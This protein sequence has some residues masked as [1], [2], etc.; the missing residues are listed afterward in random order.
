MSQWLTTPEAVEQEATWER[1]QAKPVPLPAGTVR[2]PD[3]IVRD[4]EVVDRMMNR[5]VRMLRDADNLRAVAAKALRE[6]H[7]TARLDARETD[8]TVP[9]RDAI[10][11]LAVVDEQTAVDV[12]EVAYRYAK[13]TAAWLEARKSSLQT[14]SKL[15]LATYELAG[16]NR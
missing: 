12:A 5:A 6:A 3:S 10:A 14:Q 16:V 8:G 2:T 4:L 11:L 7:A 1:D 15:V 9:E 13:E